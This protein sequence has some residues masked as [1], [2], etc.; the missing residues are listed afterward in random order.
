M[1]GE[2]TASSP[3]SDS[4]IPETDSV[5]IEMHDKTQAII[6]DYAP[7]D[8]NASTKKLRSFAGLSYTWLKILLR[9]RERIHYANFLAA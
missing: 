4:Q 3:M 2:S 1:A 8:A 6:K 9:R 7:L 5:F